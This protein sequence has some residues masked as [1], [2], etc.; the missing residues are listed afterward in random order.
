MLYAILCLFLYYFSYRYI[1]QYNGSGTS[2]TYSDTPFV[3]QIF[4]YVVFTISLLIVVCQGK[5]KLRTKT[6]STV[7]LITSI[8]VISIFWGVVNNF[9]QQIGFGIILLMPL[10][11]LTN[12]K[13]INLAVIDKIMISFWLF[14]LCYEIIQIYLFATQGRLPAL[15]YLSPKIT[16]VRFGSTWDDPNGFSVIL[17]F[18]LIY[19]IIKYRGLKKVVFMMINIFMIIISWSGTGIIANLLMFIVI[20]F[21][22]YKDKYF[23]K[24]ST[25]ILAGFLLMAGTCVLV[26]ID[27]LSSFIIQLMI[28]K[29]SSVS[30]HADSYDLSV[31]TP[32]ILIGIPDKGRMVEAGIMF[33]LLNGG[34]VMVMLFYTL[35]FLSIYKTIEKLSTAQKMD[36]PLFYG[37]L[38][39]QISFSFAMFNL[40][41]LTVWSNMGVMA[42]FMIL[43][44]YPRKYLMHYNV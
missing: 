35:L 31:L 19:G 40:P 11:Y 17:S 15:A 14:S 20:Y 43:V 6:P 5:K 22:R 38:A 32:L 3:F 7:V 21:I 13:M 2:P 9:T 42:I 44:F 1:L 10:V 34:V 23:Y 12:Y 37:I 4:K 39:Y 28:D 18:Y 41:L 29:Q 25:K 27:Y 36:K 26:N 16:D 30:A 24:K 33:L 8:T